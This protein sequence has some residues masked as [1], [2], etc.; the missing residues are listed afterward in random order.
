V[1]CLAIFQHLGEEKAKEFFENMLKNEVHLLESDGDVQDRVE[2]GD[3]AF[4]LTDNDDAME[5]IRESKGKKITMVIPDERGLGMLAP[6]AP[7]LIKNG[8]NPENGKKFIDFVLRPE[9]EMLL[10]KLASQVS[11]RLDLKL[12]EGFAYPPLEKMRGMRV[13]YRELAELHD[14]LVPGYLKDWAERN[15]QR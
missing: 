15:T 3:F 12:P 13:N 4:G 10:S 8:P 1:H 2:K 14:Q 9:A 5:A 11:L 7:V 6:D